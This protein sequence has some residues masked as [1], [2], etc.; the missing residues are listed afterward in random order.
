MT[1]RLDRVRAVELAEKLVRS[2]K[3]REAIVEYEKLIADDPQDVGTLNII[4]DLHAQSGQ[5]DRA[6][7]FFL[8]GAEEYEKRGLFSQAVAICKKV[9]KL[10]PDNPDH[11][12]KLADLYNQQGFLAEAKKEYLK[13]ADRFIREKKTQDAV[14]IYE[15]VARLDRDDLE[16]KKTLSGLYI[17]MGFT[18]A[19]VEQLNEIAEARMG[20][21]RLDAAE[22]VL[23]EG[24][25]LMTADSRTVLNLVE[26]YKRQN[27]SEKA[28]ELV[29]ESLAHTPNNVLLLNILG[30]F[31]FEKGD[32]ERAA[33]VFS[34]IVTNHPMNVNARIK[35]GRIHILKEKLDEAFELYEPLIN[36]L[37]KKQKDEKA[38]GL[39]G[40]ILESQKPHLPALDRLAS[41]YRTNKEM[42]KLEVVD[43]TILEELRKQG[44]R[45]KMLAVLSELRQ[46]RPED[47]EI[48]E[49]YQTVSE[50]L[51]ISEGE[52]PVESAELTEKDKELIQ[53][54]ISQSDL[55]MQQGLVRNARRILENLRQ[56]YPDVPQ[57]VK[58]IAVLDEIRTHMDEKEL[59]KRIEQTS[60]MEAKI[61]DKIQQEQMDEIVRKPFLVPPQEIPDEEKISTA[62]IFAETD[63]IPFVALESAAVKYYELR[64]QVAAELTMLKAAANQQI[65]GGMPQEERDLEQIVTDFKK[66]LKSKIN[67]EDPEIHYQLGLAFLEQGLYTEAVEELIVASKEKALALGCFSVI[68]TC[69]RLKKNLSDA[70]K[71]LKKALN[72]AKDG[73]DQFYALEFD[74]AELLEEKGE[75]DKALQL[76]AKIRDWNP[77]FRDVSAKVESLEKRAA[78]Q[79]A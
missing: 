57:I 66:D 6:V 4:G 14:H 2:G 62:D 45:E 63:I 79:A 39:L 64:D 9:I 54:T 46:L 58:K 75:G 28:I 18:D 33:E 49:E 20:Q 69:C 48:A 70:E 37:V 36:S 77:G 27:R 17:E 35:L 5:N 32:F 56:R 19:A 11:A 8:R 3:I 40:L 68:S 30:N 41:I 10:S 7:Q 34:A 43:R 42:K 74:M 1:S 24:M 78:G 59:R 76:Y 73:S 25:T 52:A 51:G 29:E 61:K 16:I 44:S 26:V 53:E 15:K 72:L 23:H 65:Q 38:I 13:L 67:H 12:L 60:A 50:D 22:K 31:N 71:W 47:A 21:D 55:Y